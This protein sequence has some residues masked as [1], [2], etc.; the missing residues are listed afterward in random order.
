[1]A[2]TVSTKNSTIPPRRS[3]PHSRA[4]PRFLWA[5]PNLM[6][7]RQ[8]QRLA[9]K[10]TSS[11]DEPDNNTRQRA[12]NVHPSFVRFNRSFVRQPAVAGRKAR[13]FKA[14]MQ[15]CVLRR[16]DFKTHRLYGVPGA[17]YQYCCAARYVRY[18]TRFENLSKSDNACATIVEEE[19]TVHA[20]IFRHRLAC[21]TVQKSI[22]ACNSPARPPSSRCLYHMPSLLQYHTPFQ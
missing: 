18:M 19:P 11:G 16:S 17:C 21:P 2:R 3:I 22:H 5:S 13:D 4:V 10:Q 6:S 12:G 15:E 9:I 14:A 8:I 20:Q 7:T 1:M